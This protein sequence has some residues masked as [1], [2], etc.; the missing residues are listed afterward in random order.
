MNVT[1]HVDYKQLCMN[2]LGVDSSERSHHIGLV[3]APTY[4]HLG[5]DALGV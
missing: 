5:D 2:P 1:M 4:S 3:V